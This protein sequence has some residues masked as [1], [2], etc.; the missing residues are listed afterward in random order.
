MGF[1]SRLLRP[2]PPVAAFTEARQDGMP[3]VARQGYEFGI[4]H[5]GVETDERARSAG[6][7][8]QQVMEQLYQAYLACSPASACVDTTARMVTAGGLQLVPESGEEDQERPPAIQ[9]LD[10]LMRNTNPREDMVQLLRSTITDLLCFGDGFIE[11][12]TVANVVAALWTLD[13]TTVAVKSDEHG[14][15][16]GYLQYI[17]GSRQASF[18]AEEVVQVSLDSPRGGIYGVS[19]MQKLMV[20]ITSWLFTAAVLKEYMRQGAPPRIAVDL[21]KGTSPTDVE[22][23]RGQYVGRNLGA[24]NQGKPI[25][26][27]VHPAGSAGEPPIKELTV[28]HIADLLATLNDL[29]DQIV[30]GFGMSPA[31]IGII[32]SGNLGG[33]TGEAQARTFHYGTVV[34]LQSLL[35]E[36]LNFRLLTAQGITGWKFQFGEIEYRDTVTVEAQRKSRI[37]TGQWTVN[38]ARAEIG[39][40]PVEGGDVAVLVLSRNVV[41]IEDLGESSK[42]TVVKDSGGAYGTPAGYVP[43]APAVP[44]PPADAEPSEPPD[45]GAQ[46]D[47]KESTP[48][49]DARRLR[50]AWVTAYREQLT[51]VRRELAEAGP[52]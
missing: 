52:E 10:A 42:A 45:A 15:L 22:R 46:D 17:D 43:P 21:G 34:P 24:R 14:E 7:S 29:R 26:T 4:P 12:G 1:W 33:G 36:K 27:T 6:A 31:M 28:S 51:A 13:G 19:P 41:A 44:V 11:F 50:E 9:Q 32:E 5:G 16:T 30:S 23:W 25:V 37:D 48:A 40:P 39:E 18:T 47:A 35:L 20:P 49:G 3:D 2:E 8:R 38:R